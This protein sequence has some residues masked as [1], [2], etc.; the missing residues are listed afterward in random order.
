MAALCF[1]KDLSLNMELTGLVTSAAH[2]PLQILLFLLLQIWSYR[3]APHGKSRLWA[4]Y[5][6]SLASCWCPC[7]IG[8]RGIHLNPI[9]YISLLNVTHQSYT[10][11][12]VVTAYQLTVKVLSGRDHGPW[13]RL[14]W[15]IKEVKSDVQLWSWDLNTPF[16]SLLANAAHSV[17]RRRQGRG[18]CPLSCIYP[19]NNVSP[20]WIVPTHRGNNCQRLETFLVVINQWD[21]SW[22]LVGRGQSYW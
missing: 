19:E 8:D 15:A 12:G 16:I 5:A 2:Q 1:G 3:N 9:K 20:I 10:I 7:R 22:H 21:C 6:I 14:N 17:M 4:L 18:I 13:H 11:P